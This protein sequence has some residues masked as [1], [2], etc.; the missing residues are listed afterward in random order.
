MSEI[1]LPELTEATLTGA[2][3]FDILM[4][5][6]KVH[7]DEQYAANRIKGGEFATVYLGSLE[8]VMAGSIQFLIQS[9]KAGLE[10]DLIAKQI[11]LAGV[12]V[13]KANAELLIIQQGLPKIQA[14]IAHLNAQTALTTQQKENAIIEHAVLVAT[15]CKLRAE[16]DLLQANVLK[17]GAEN[18]LLLQKVATEKAQIL[19]LG[20]DDNSVIGKQK[21]LYQAQ[22]DGFARDA[23]QKAAKILVDTWNARR[24]TDEATIADGTNLLNDVAI[25]RTI[26]K[27]LAGVNA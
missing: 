27:L 1:T 24:M 5:A 12:E 19:S 14:E 10:A 17:A 2:G 16:Y 9:R 26:S 18:A 13:L 6:N 23:E 20:V 25:G 22:T 8:A 4:K 21:A 3:V 15:E 7:L 11:E